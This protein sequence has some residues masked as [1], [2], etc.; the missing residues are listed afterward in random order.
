MAAAPA[1]G[2]RGAH[3]CAELSDGRNLRNLGSRDRRRGAEE[4]PEAVEGP[5]P[6]IPKEQ[7]QETKEPPRDPKLSPV[8]EAK[9]EEA[10]HNERQVDAEL[11]LGHPRLGADRCGE[12][13]V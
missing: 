5:L 9:D 8:V 1:Y 7:E 6:K 12:L 13:M 10:H 11:K 2:G 4:T 3:V